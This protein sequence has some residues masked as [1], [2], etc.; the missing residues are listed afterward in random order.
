MFKIVGYLML[1]LIVLATIT[2]GIIFLSQINNF[3]KEIS[4]KRTWV[5]DGSPKNPQYQGSVKGFGHSA[6]ENHANFC[7]ECGLPREAIVSKEELTSKINQQILKIF[8]VGLLLIISTVMGIL[9]HST[10]KS[11]NLLCPKGTEEFQGICIDYDEWFSNG[12]RIL[13]EHQKN[14]NLNLGVEA[15][16]EDKYDRAISYFNKAVEASRNDPEP[17]IY[18][19][20]ARARLAGSPFVLAVVVPIDNGQAISQEIL[21]GVADAQ[22]IFNNQGGVGNRLLEI[23]I[24][25]DAN[26]PERSAIV[27]HRIAQNPKIL[28]IIGHYSSISSLEALPK[29]EKENLAMVSPNST[30][31]VLSSDVFFRTVPSDRIMGERL[32]E[33]ARNRLNKESIG[34]FSSSHSSYSLS[35]VRAFE[36]KFN[37]LG[38]KVINLIDFNDF[39]LDPDQVLQTL[40]NSQIDLIALFPNTVNIPLA[41]SVAK[42]NAKLPAEQKFQL[43]GNDALY[44]SA[45]LIGGGSAVEGLVLSITGLSGSEKF[46][47]EAAKKWGGLTN[48]RTAS[49]FDATQAFIDA[50]SRSDNPSRKSILQNLKTVNLSSA[51]TS[52]EPLSFSSTGERFGETI[53]VQVAK[54]SNDVSAPG[55]S[56]FGFKVVK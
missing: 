27:A 50:L 56:E 41:I 33:Y 51:E 48:W 44:N 17:Q 5:C 2:S 31:D 13:F 55:G 40:I 10:T 49:A 54:M 53:L 1:F 39:E 29:Y 28:G 38:G 30:S 43:I 19:N 16:K 12:N 15:F 20:N 46:V 34:I 14:R 36:Q 24:A 6:I 25:N 35:I 4:K 11:L 23:L 45:T 8:F 32:A 52:G 42:A 21:R 7:I 47:E 9:V 22:T 26:I 37:Q 3:K 18:L